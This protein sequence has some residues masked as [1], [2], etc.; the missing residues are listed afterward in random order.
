M[1]AVSI[2]QKNDNMAIVSHSILSIYDGLLSFTVPRPATITLLAFLF[3][4]VFRGILQKSGNTGPTFKPICCFSK[5]RVLPILG[6]SISSND[7]VA[8]F[9]DH[10]R[11][12]V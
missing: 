6:L 12:A 9:L 5:Q 7:A 8:S 11:S 2:Q 4:N 1:D 3:N 10:N